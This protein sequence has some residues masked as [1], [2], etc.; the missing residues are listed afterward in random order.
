MDDTQKFP[1]GLKKTETNKIDKTNN[2]IDA[3]QNN[4]YKQ[5]GNFGVGDLSNSRIENANFVGNLSISYNRNDD[6]SS[7]QKSLQ[8]FT[9]K[10]EVISVFSEEHKYN[11]ELVFFELLH[12]C[13]EEEKINYKNVLVKLTITFNEARESFSFPVTPWRNSKNVTVR[14]GIKRGELYLNL[15]RTSIP[16]ENRKTLLSDYWNAEPVG[17][18]KLPKWV[19]KPLA[20]KDILEGKLEGGHLVTNVDLQNNDF[21]E[22]IFKVDI[23]RQD[24]V[25]NFLDTVDENKKRKETKIAAF[26]KY[27][28]PKLKDYVGKVKL[29]LCPSH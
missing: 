15:D 20:G 16:L 26:L 18:N 11:G 3:T 12:F 4:Y 6:F 1:Q 23:N 29:K 8:E 25:V 10:L 2:E 24:I 17:T 13:K 19:F 5:N 7:N 22:A 28:E 9:K 21:I 14:F 27:I